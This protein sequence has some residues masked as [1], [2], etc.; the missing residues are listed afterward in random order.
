MK[1]QLKK[2][3]QGKFSDNQ[4]KLRIDRFIS[5]WLRITK[6]LGGWKSLISSIGM[7]VD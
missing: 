7:S 6:T 3:Y 4:L 2:G 5:F 1:K